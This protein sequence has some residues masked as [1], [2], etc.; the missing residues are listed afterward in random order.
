MYDD[1]RGSED[2]SHDSDELYARMFREDAKDERGVLVSCAPEVI[3]CIRSA[4]FQYNGSAAR[5]C[6]Q[7]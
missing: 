1:A 5:Y 3:V 4:Y 2:G 7:R 6:I